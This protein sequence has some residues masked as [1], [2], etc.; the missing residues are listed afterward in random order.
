MEICIG[1]YY[2]TEKETIGN[3]HMKTFRSFL[4]EVVRVSENKI[5]DGTKVLAKGVFAKGLIGGK[6][7]TMRNKPPQY[8]KE[9]IGFYRGKDRG[10]SN[11]NHYKDDVDRW[12]RSGTDLNGLEI[13]KSTTENVHETSE[14]S[15][16][17]ISAADVKVIRQDLKKEFPAFKF[18]VRLAH[19]GHS[20]L[21]VDILSGPVRFRKDDGDINVYH[22][23][24]YENP[25]I[26]K[27][28]VATINKKNFDKSEIQIDYFHV[29]F[30]LNLDQGQDKWTGSK[31]T[32]NAFVLTDA[33][34]KKPIDSKQTVPTSEEL[35]Y[36]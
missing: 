31:N 11:V 12:L 34:G 3:T 9:I 33:S 21:K 1:I 2:T 25:T 23:D 10:I 20:S 22:I 15:E 28:I 32:K 26:L 29:G 18:A 19:G 4:T 17:Y 16:A 14:L 8:G 36:E 24:Q 6:V 27:K 7:Y 30:Y 35:E 5:I 13:V